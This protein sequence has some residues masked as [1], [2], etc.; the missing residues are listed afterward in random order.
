MENFVLIKGSNK[1]VETIYQIIKQRINWMDSNKIEQWNKTDYL[2]SY[3]IEYFKEKVTSGELYV[4]KDE[5]SDKVV[6]AV[7]LLEEDQRWK[8]DGVKSYYLH[9]LVSDT[10]VPG[11][12][13]RIIDLCEKLASRNGKDRLRLDCQSTNTKLNHYYYRLGFKYVGNVQVGNYYGT[14]REKVKNLF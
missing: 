11:I 7:V 12:G 10:E 14:K 13:N 4:M 2:K 1:D 8:K 9:N 6:G 3:P 5:S